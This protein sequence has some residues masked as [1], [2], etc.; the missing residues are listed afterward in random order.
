MFFLPINKHGAQAREAA[1]A[2]EEAYASDAQ[3]IIFSC[4]SMLEKK[5][6]E[7]KDLIWQKSFIAK[8]IRHKRTI[9]PVYFSGRNSDFFYN[10]SNIRTALE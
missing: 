6:G 9:V 8:A 4:R 3:I 1:K 2:I 7:I 10:L 5:K